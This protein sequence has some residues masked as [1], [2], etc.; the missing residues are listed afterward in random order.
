MTVFELIAALEALPPGLPVLLDLTTPHMDQFK[1]VGLRFADEISYE[2]EAGQEV[3]VV[4][5]SHTEPSE[6]PDW[7]ALN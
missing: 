6:E 1:F 5:L 3:P 4:L 2:G 7:S